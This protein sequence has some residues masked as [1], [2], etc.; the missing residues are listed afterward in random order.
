MGWS[1]ANLVNVVTFTTS[2]SQ[3]RVIS[4][5]GNLAFGNVAVGSSFQRTLTIS[6]NGNSTL[7]VSS[8]SYPSGF[9][10]SWSGAIPASGSQNVTVTFSPSSATGYSGNITVSSDSLAV[11]LPST[12]DGFA[13]GAHDFRDD[14][15]WQT[16]RGDR[17]SC[18]VERKVWS[19]SGGRRSAFR[20]IS[21][22][23][24]RASTHGIRR[25]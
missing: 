20:S 16:F 3:T 22:G 19:F 2:V 6:N 12:R 13:G 17:S 7:N 5:S 8:I 15:V 1:D 4:L 21:L 9:S 14:D 25:G 10:G 11:R 18:P 24:A 23:S